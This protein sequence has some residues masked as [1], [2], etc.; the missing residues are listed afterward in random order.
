MYTKIINPAKH[1]KVAYSN[2]GS[3][4]ALVNYLNKENREF[5]LID[6]ELFFDQHRNNVTSNE[7]LQAIDSNHKGLRRNIPKFHSLVIAPTAQELYHI[8]Q[9]TEA[10]KDY[11]RG[12]ME[13]Y[14]QSFNLANGQKLSS[15]DL[16]WFAKLEHMRNGE[17]SAN[18]M[19]IHVIVSARD[20]SQSI[21][22]NPNINNRNR[23]NRVQFYL[24]SEKAFDKMFG[25]NRK[26]SLLLSHQIQRYGSLSEK[27]V[28]YQENTNLLKVQ[29]A[30]HNVAS[31]FQGLN[32][33]N[34]QE[35]IRKRRRKR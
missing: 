19:H 24:K 13:Q 27:L 18:S 2:A 10:M 12:V 22:L 8:K 1:G 9:S 5:Q 23:F 20:K 4:V 17:F 28:L 30:I 26:E 14:A 32:Y 34:E 15:E 3:C 35:N 31:V 11:T 25:F 7:V 21:T 29:E 16:T 33:D 6:N